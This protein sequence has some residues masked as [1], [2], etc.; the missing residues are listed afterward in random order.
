MHCRIG[1]FAIL[2]K[3]EHMDCPL[4][5]H[6]FRARCLPIETGELVHRRMGFR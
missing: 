2:E 6:E 3:E 4:G 1:N 5:T